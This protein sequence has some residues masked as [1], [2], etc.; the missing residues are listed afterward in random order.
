MANERRGAGLPGVGPLPQ[1]AQV[2]PV[3][4]PTGEPFERVRK[5][6]DQLAKELAKATEEQ[7]KLRRERMKSAMRQKDMQKAM[8]AR[9]KTSGYF[10]PPSSQANGHGWVCSSYHYGASNTISRHF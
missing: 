4:G 9:P 6:A 7:A 1:G 5:S 10:Q 2:P 8:R 3:F